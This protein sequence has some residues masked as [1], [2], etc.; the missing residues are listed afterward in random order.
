MIWN[1]EMLEKWNVLHMQW[2]ALICSILLP[3]WYL[4]CN[5]KFVKTNVGYLSNSCVPNI[6]HLP[7]SGNMCISWR[8]QW[9]SLCTPALYKLQSAY[10]GSDHLLLAYVT[11]RVRL[12]EIPLKMQDEEHECSRWLTRLACHETWRWQWACI[13]GGK[14]SS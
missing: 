14:K 8:Q 3:E 7:P 4:L 11:L 10:I 1:S 12:E 13:T 2:F 9:R 5:D 6:V